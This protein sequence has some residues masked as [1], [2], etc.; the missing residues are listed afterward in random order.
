M[1]IVSCNSSTF[2]NRLFKDKKGVKTNKRQDLT[3][4]SSSAVPPQFVFVVVRSNCAPSSSATS[5]CAAVIATPAINERKAAVS[6]CSALLTISWEITHDKR[7][8]S[9]LMIIIEYLSK[10]ASYTS[11]DLK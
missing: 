2:R 7:S 4:I 5:S 9:K 10:I 3:A 6:S 11:C 8:G 1:R